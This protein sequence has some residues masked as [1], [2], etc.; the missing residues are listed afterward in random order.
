MVV[1]QNLLPGAAGASVPDAAT[2]HATSFDTT[3][4]SSSADVS[5]QVEVSLDNGATWNPSG[6]CAGKGGT[7]VST[8]GITPSTPSLGSALLP[9]VSRLVRMRMQAPAAVVASG[10]IAL[11]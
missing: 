1:G 7:H 9:G 3:N 5:V 2:H 11:S 10:S 4:F 6:A 8:D